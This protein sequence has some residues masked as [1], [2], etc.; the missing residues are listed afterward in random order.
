MPATSVV[1]P[2]ISV[3]P[4]GPVTTPVLV[5]SG[6]L[7]G[8]SVNV[9]HAGSHGLVLHAVGAPRERP[10]K[11]GPRP[12]SVGAASVTALLMMH[13]PHSWPSQLV[14]PWPQ[15]TASPTLL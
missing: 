12:L 8:L 15:T 7:A 1:A 2:L 14:M 5:E 4:L 13:S 11:L 6:T 10:R 9:L 3:T